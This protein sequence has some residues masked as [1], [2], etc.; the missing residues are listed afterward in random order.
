[1]IL[2][3]KDTIFIILLL[4]LTE[5]GKSKFKKGGVQS[6]SYNADNCVINTCEWVSFHMTVV[7]VSDHLQSFK[8]SWLKAKTL[9]RR[10]KPSVLFLFQIPDPWDRWA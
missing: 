3:L 4:Y 1:M 8:S 9:P 2:L 10:D 7:P 6:N 5:K